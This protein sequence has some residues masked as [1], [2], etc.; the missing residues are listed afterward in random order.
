[1]PSQGRPTR[2][3]RKAL[4]EA[5]RYPLRIPQRDGSIKLVPIYAP[6]RELA[7]ARHQS[8][9][10]QILRSRQSGQLREISTVHENLRLRALIEE[11][12]LRLPPEKRM[13]SSAEERLLARRMHLGKMP[14]LSKHSRP[15][16]K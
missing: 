6:T 15:R 13:S 16:G 4:G 2:T 14:P 5:F 1:M 8:G 9:T 7:R 10:R 12:N 3:R 11:M